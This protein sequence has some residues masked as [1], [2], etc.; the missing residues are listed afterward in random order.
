M[1]CY[2]A[3]KYFKN[4]FNGGEVMAWFYVGEKRF[5]LKKRTYIMGILNVTPDSFSDGGEYSALDK[6]I[7]RARKIEEEGADI[8]DIGGQSTR[9]GYKIISQEE[10]WARVKPVLFSIKKLAIPISIDTFYPYVAER[11]LDMGAVVINDV[12]GFGDKN[13]VK[14][15]AK[16][17]ASCV[18]MSNSSLNEVFENLEDKKHELLQNGV[19]IEKICFDPGV[20]FGKTHSENLQILESSVDF[21]PRGAAVLIGASRKRVTAKACDNLPPKERSAA[22]IAAHTLAIAGGADIIRV[23]DVKE[24]VQAAKMADEILKNRNVTGT[25]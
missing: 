19:E 3:N 2:V 14:L 10:E 4:I 13:M 9:P 6:A 12:S 1:F 25:V 18:V 5:L 21:V 22:T 11:A 7:E 23:H 8:L 16:T 24:G 15:A 17:G 20:G